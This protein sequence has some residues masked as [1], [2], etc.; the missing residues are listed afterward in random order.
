LPLLYRPTRKFREE[1]NQH[2]YI[3]IKQNETPSKTMLKTVLFSKLTMTEQPSS[4]KKGN[5]TAKIKYFFQKNLYFC[6]H[7]KRSSTSGT[8][9]TVEPAP[10]R[11]GRE[12]RLTADSPPPPPPACHQS[13][14]QPLYHQHV[15]GGRK[16]G[17]TGCGPA[18]SFVP[19][20]LCNFT[21]VCWRYASQLW[22]PGCAC[23][24]A[25]LNSEL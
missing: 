15:A 12:Q 16:G 8:P 17:R 18:P 6:T 25:C 24:A 11:R 4:D 21:A 22:W 14:N 23:G 9:L 7:F 1:K 3:K 20:V 5:K 19:E 13:I 2:L 10:L